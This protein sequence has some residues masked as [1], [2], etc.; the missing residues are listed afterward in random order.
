MSSELATEAFV[1]GEIDSFR[2]ATKAFV[3]A[4]IDS[5]RGEIRAEIDSFRGEIRAEIDAFRTETNNRFQSVD[6]DIKELK[7]DVRQLK[8]TM[9]EMQVTMRQIE[10]R[11]RN[12]RLKNPISRIRPIPI[13][14]DGRGAQEPDARFFPKYADQLY[15][16]RKP[17]NDSEHQML[18]YLSKF[19]DIWQEAVDQSIDDDI[20]PE[21]A[22]ELL[23][24]ILGLDEE[25]FVASR[26]K[27]RLL[28]SQTPAAA[29]KRPRPSTDSSGAAPEPIRRKLKTP[30]DGTPTVPFTETPSRAPPPGPRLQQAQEAGRNPSDGSPTVPLTD[31]IPPTEDPGPA[32]AATLPARP[33]HPST[34]PDSEE[35]SGS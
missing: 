15:S 2:L 7:T 32:P 17:Q 13:Y 31:S 25:R 28:A 18:A 4:E 11:A 35:T 29:E 24:E 1:K 34:I 19:Y 22:V 8:V 30:S 23:E 20:D 5:F 3:K 12:G 14:V 27:A 9:S 21:R 10:V 6:A 26:A 16:L 33:R